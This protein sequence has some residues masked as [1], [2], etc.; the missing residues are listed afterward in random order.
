MKNTSA[1]VGSSRLE[2]GSSPARVGS[3]PLESGSSAVFVA[4]TLRNDVFIVLFTFRLMCFA[5]FVCF[6]LFSMFVSVFA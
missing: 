3:S 4:G 2:S 5:M 1:R 6:S